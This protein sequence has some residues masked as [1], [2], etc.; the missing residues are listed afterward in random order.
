MAN[1]FLG[2]ARD[3]GV[4]GAEPSTA[5]LSVEESS[6]DMV[7]Q[8]LEWPD[9]GELFWRWFMLWFHAP[10]IPS[11]SYSLGLGWFRAFF[12]FAILK[13]FRSSDISDTIQERV[14]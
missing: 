13:N 3:P 11:L 9:P 7:S 10:C 14:Y 12:V 6:R 8:G 5:P 4:I 2:T 1:V